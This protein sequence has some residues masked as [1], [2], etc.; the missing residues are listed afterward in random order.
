MDAQQ[1]TRKIYLL[2]VVDN[3]DTYR[4]SFKLGD[5]F[6]SIANLALEETH[7]QNRSLP[8]WK[9][10]NRHGQVLDFNSKLSDYHIV[11]R[12]SLYLSSIKK[13]KKE[14]GISI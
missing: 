11:S 5:T 1:I 2:I 4:G 14:R 13:Y 9:I 8:N 3:Q 10:S 12:D 6:K 7:M